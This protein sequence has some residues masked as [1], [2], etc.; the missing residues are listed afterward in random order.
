MTHKDRRLKW[1]SK[2]QEMET[3]RLPVSLSRIIRKKRR[4]LSTE[5]MVKALEAA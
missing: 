1:K 5:A 4:Q 2:G 3:L